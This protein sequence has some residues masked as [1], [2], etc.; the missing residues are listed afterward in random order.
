MVFDPASPAIPSSKRPKVILV[1]DDD[2]VRG[3]LG[4]LL[5]AAGYEVEAFA[6]G[7]AYLGQTPPASPACL[8]LDMRM[9]GMGG[10]E[11]ARII[12][13]TA[14]ALPVVFITGHGDEAARREALAQGAVDVLFKPL[15]ADALMAAIERAL[16]RSAV[17]PAAS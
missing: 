17:V 3:S 4:R 13:G 15:D 8:V 5:R 6:G 2:S 9:P 7:D 16:G 14:L 10:L 11:L 1:D 12:A